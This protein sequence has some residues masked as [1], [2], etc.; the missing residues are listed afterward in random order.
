MNFRLFLALSVL[1]ILAVV[2]ANNEN[3]SIFSKIAGFFTSQK[4]NAVKTT[5]PQKIDDGTL[6]SKITEA[7]SHMADGNFTG[8]VENLLTVLESIADHQR[9]NALMG[10]SFLA[11]DRADLAESFLF[12]A[13][14]KSNYSDIASITNL[15]ESLR[16]NGDSDLALEVLQTSYSLHKNTTKGMLEFEMGEVLSSKQMFKEASDWFLASALL[17]SDR[18]SAWLRA[19]TLQFPAESV[20]YDLAESVLMRAMSAIPTSADIAFNLGTPLRHFSFKITVIF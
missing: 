3:N 2:N 13:V 6:Q 5:Q 4:K 7:E 12:T 1:S 16:L 9:A 11:L 18:E 14:R 20:N 8:A 15:A 10:T 17:Q 19:S